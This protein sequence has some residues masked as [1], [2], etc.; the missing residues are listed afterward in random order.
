MADYD[1]ST[2]TSSLAQNLR[3]VVSRTVNTTSPLLRTLRIEAGEGKNVAWA[4][5]LDGAVAENFSD[6]A[7]V[8]NYGSDVP[9]FANL[10]WGLYRSNFRVTNLAASA[11]QSSR[12][13]AGLMNLMARS[14]VNS[15][16]KL[17][18]TINAA[19]YAGA[20]TGTLIAGLN[21]GINDSNT[22]GG[23][24]RGSTPKFRAKKFDPGSLTE[25]TIALIRSDIGAIYDECGE[26]VDLGFAPTS[27]WNK[28][29]ALFQEQRRYNQD[30]FLG[31]RRVTLDNS[32]DA[33]VIDGVL[34]LKDK[35][36]TANGIYY[37]NSNYVYWEYLPP[38]QFSALPE[39]STTMQLEDT[40]GSLGLQVAV[41]P[42]ARTGAA[43]KVTCEA[44]LQL[45]VEKP[46]SC[47][48]R[49]NVKDT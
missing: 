26:K 21:V 30:I 20:G 34:F 11:A 19:G 7:D 47:G 8:S 41:Y 25:P 33:I 45:V 15:A 31:S 9:A 10:Q 6:G 48:V 23:I 46:N 44:Q 18:T 36:A 12:T 1:L 17:A 29:A 28:L 37:I 49:L 27:V 42:L 3:N 14:L 32:V 16:R 5:E 2:I 4:V 40:Q 13:P 24:V 38:A 43:R 22:Y 35:D 39:Q